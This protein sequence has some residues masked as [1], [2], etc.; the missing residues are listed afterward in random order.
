[1][2]VGK[3]TTENEAE[4]PDTGNPWKPVFL[5]LKSLVVYQGVHLMCPSY[6]RYWGEHFYFK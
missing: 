4:R 6:F 1:M 5:K 2:G 3:G